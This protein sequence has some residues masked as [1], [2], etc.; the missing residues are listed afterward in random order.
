MKLPIQ[1]AIQRQMTVICVTLVCIFGCSPP[2]P[3]DPDFRVAFPTE[4]Q[5]K[6]LSFKARFVPTNG[7]SNLQN[8]NKLYEF[9]REFHRHGNS[10]LFL[11]TSRDLEQSVS[12]TLIAI[13][14][15]HLR[16]LGVREDNTL[17]K[18]NV[19]S[20]T[21]GAPEVILSF[22]GAIVKV[23]ECG[24]WSGEAGFNPT[25]LPGKNYGCSYQRNIGLMVSDPS[26]FR[27]GTPHGTIDAQRLDQ[28]I[29]NYR[30]GTPT[31]AEWESGSGGSGSTGTSTQ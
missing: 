8:A 11:S 4:V 10:R 30:A 21:K 1:R 27:R 9:V 25:N 29:K 22:R 28:V 19:A 24:D 3:G 18:P 31:G 23:P 6:T 16:I 26:D 14:Q 12:D 13:T 2:A 15:K 5:D 7:E 17:V 20:P